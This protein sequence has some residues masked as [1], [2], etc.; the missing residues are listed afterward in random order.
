MKILIRPKDH[1]L[2]IIIQ[3]S[4]SMPENLLAIIYSNSLSNTR[5]PF[6]FRT[7]CHC[8]IHHHAKVIKNVMVNHLFR[9]GSPC[10]LSI[11]VF[12]PWRSVYRFG[13]QPKW[14]LWQVGENQQ[15]CHSHT[16]LS[17][18]SSRDG[19]LH[20]WNGDCDSCATWVDASMR[21]MLRPMQACS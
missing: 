20:P 5:V 21:E 6:H 17:T 4:M 16:S 14:C 10:W 13:I 18:D 7:I 8:H 3:F 1:Q 12:C 11:L 15:A 9:L 19:P 2:E